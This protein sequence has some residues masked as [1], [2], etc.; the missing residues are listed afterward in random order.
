VLFQNLLHPADNSVL[1][2]DFD[3]VR[4]IGRLGEQLLHDAFGQRSCAL[5]L[6]FDHANA[7]PRLHVRANS[8]VHRKGYFFGVIFMTALFVASAV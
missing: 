1:Q 4:M 8:S 6:F 5:V 3:P 2:H 7:K